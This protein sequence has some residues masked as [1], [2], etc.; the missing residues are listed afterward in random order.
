MAQEPTIEQLLLEVAWS[1][2]QFDQASADVKKVRDAMNQAVDT[3]KEVTGYDE[4][5]NQLDSAKYKVMQHAILHLPEKRTSVPDVGYVDV[6][7]Q[8]PEAMVYNMWTL[9]ADPAAHQFI[10]SITLTESA[11]VHLLAGREIP[12]VK[13]VDRIPK[14]RMSV[15]EYLEKQGG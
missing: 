15:K 2:L 1:T 7:P 12:G 13:L 5:K 14:V 6:T 4:R 9:L 3:M 11:A 10:E 8:D